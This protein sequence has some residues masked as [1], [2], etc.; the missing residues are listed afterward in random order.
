[1]DSPESFSKQVADYALGTCR[2]NA[3]IADRFDLDIDEVE[4]VLLDA[5]IERCSLCGWWYESGELTPDE[6]TEEYSD[7]L[8]GLCQD[9]RTGR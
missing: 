1:M 7:D 2:S 9:C 8:V 6:D 3:E 5:N 4:E